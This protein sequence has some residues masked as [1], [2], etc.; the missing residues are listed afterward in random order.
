ML[1]KQIH[2]TYTKQFTPPPKITSKAFIIIEKNAV[3]KFFEP[4][5]NNNTNII[6]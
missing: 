4:K 2:K 6:K 1:R 5:D 3:K